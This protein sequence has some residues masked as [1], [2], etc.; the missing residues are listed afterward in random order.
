[1]DYLDSLLTL[2]EISVAF[3]G[4]ASIVVIFKR[5]SSGEWDGIDAFRFRGMLAYS[6]LAALFSVTPLPLHA[7]GLPDQLV[8]A[9]GSS[10]LGGYFAWMLWGHAH[11]PQRWPVPV[12]WRVW[13]IAHALLWIGFFTQL[14]NVAGLW[15]HREPGPYV[16]GITLL[17][18]G[19]GWSFFN[20][21]SV[22]DDR[23]A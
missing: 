3:T 19:A 8:W 7:I 20:L 18:T 11:L 4:F 14:L 16:L 5:R 17:L 23:R 1:M 15:F 9:I 22:T 10:A 21:V 13:T 2:A 12:N 6:L